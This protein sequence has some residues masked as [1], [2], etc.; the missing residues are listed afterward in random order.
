MSKSK[1]ITAD[2]GKA[3][4]PAALAEND[5]GAVTGGVNHSEFRIVKLVDAATPVLAGVVAGL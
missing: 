3:S 2:I 5:L 1:I 4:E